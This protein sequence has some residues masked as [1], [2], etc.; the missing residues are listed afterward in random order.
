MVGLIDIFYFSGGLLFWI[1]GI[2]TFREYKKNRFKNE[3]YLSLYFLGVGWLFPLILFFPYDPTNEASI[4]FIKFLFIG[5]NA[6]IPLVVIFLN[7]FIDYTVYEGQSSWTHLNLYIGGGIT[8]LVFTLVD[9]LEFI[10]ITTVFGEAEY[11]IMNVDENSPSLVRFVFLMVYVIVILNLVRFGVVGIRLAKRNANNE[12]YKMVRR[13]I[14]LMFT[15][16][17]L[18]I[19]ISLLKREYPRYLI[20]VDFIVNALFYSLLVVYYIRHHELFYFL[21]S[22]LKLAILID[23]SGIHLCDYNFSTKKIIDDEDNFEDN[24][25]AL[26]RSVLFGATIAI[27]NVLQREIGDEI[28]QEIN[29]Q[30]SKIV[31]YQST[32]FYIW[33]VCEQYS[34]YYSAIITKIA[35]RIEETYKEE[36]NAMAD[37]SRPSWILK[38]GIKAE[39]DRIS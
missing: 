11:I 30:N 22:S 15:G 29:F 14:M 28:L 34:Q 3:L 4:N 38:Q 23:K 37:G 2:L 17:F 25:L 16:L 5:A 1:L 27:E 36:F 33:L 7:L 9:F 10:P 8:F 21:P 19:L 39:F 20:G 12:N 32:H 13:I 26:V 24:S 31:L 35:Q 6:T 18:W